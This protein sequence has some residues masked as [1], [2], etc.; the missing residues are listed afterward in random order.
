MAPDE[1]ERFLNELSDVIQL[2]RDAYLIFSF[3]DMF[4]NK[5]FVEVKGADLK[6]PSPEKLNYIQDLF[7][8]YKRLRSAGFHPTLVVDA[9]N[10][11][12]VGSLKG[13]SP[14]DTYNVLRI[15]DLDLSTA[16]EEQ[17]KRLK[18][19]LGF[20]KNAFDDQYGALIVKVTMNPSVLNME[21]F[22]TIIKLLGICSEKDE[23]CVYKARQELS[24]FPENLKDTFIK[25]FAE[26]MKKGDTYRTKYLSLFAMLIALVNYYGYLTELGRQE[27]TSKWVRKLREKEEEKARNALETLKQSLNL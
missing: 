13:L 12:L 11:L 26:M 3:A 17:L 22:K 9:N 21:A 27:M 5:D 16:G 18:S 25:N 23:A 15:N 10:T 4:K 19:F 1:F 14:N 2:Y 8:A 20:I 24:A 6:E 7:D